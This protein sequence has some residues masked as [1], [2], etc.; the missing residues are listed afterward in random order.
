MQAQTRSVSGPRAPLPNFHQR[1]ENRRHLA[2]FLRRAAKVHHGPPRPAT[3]SP[4][5]QAALTRGLVRPRRR[6][7][8]QEVAPARHPPLSIHSEARVASR[9]LP[10]STRYSIS[11]CAR[12]VSRRRSS[13]SKLF[14]LRNGLPS[15]LG[16]HERLIYRVRHLSQL[17]K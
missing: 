8:S 4:R 11:G 13:V 7:R 1:M 14:P 17:H 2:R 16:F 9:T 6:T 15:L 10:I 5:N 3:P 12:N